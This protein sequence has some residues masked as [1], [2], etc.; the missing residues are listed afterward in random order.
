MGMSF[1]EMIKMDA[2]E[3]NAMEDKLRREL[4]DLNLQIK[5]GQGTKISEVTRLRREIARVLTA[6]NK[7]IEKVEEREGR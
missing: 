1:Q 7:K 6:K 4:A 3:L 2:P 5:M